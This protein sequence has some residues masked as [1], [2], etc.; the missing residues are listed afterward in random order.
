MG[1][2]FLVVA[3]LLGPLMATAVNADQTS[4]GPISMADLQTMVQNMGY[5]IK[6]AGN[7]FY[8]SVMTQA[9]YNISF[10]I[11]SDNYLYIFANMA[12]LTSQQVQALDAQGLL[13]ANDL[14]AEFFSLHGNTDGSVGLYL[15]HVLPDIG[16]TPNLIRRTLDGLTAR[17]DSTRS[18]WNLPSAAPSAS[19]A[20]PASSSQAAPSSSTQ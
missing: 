18:L 4:P 13:K 7:I 2:R 14:G 15:N 6:P 9:P 12:N 20:E 3:A 19:S 17:G 1:Y 11:G 5:D 8:I 16:V 10:S